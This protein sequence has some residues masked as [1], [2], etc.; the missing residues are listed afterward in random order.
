MDAERLSRFYER[1]ELED[2]LLEGCS[3]N[4]VDFPLRGEAH[5]PAQY[6]VR[7]RPLLPLRRR[8]APYIPLAIFLL[9]CLGLALALSPWVFLAAVFTQ[10]N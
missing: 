10:N 8:T 4:V 5:P 7:R 1:T 9:K 2:K 3:S 6:A